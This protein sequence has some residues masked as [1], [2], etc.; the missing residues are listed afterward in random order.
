MVFVQ[1]KI[2]IAAEDEP[3]AE[4]FLDGAG[5]DEVSIPGVGGVKLLPAKAE[6]VRVKLFQQFGLVGAVFGQFGD[7]FHPEAEVLVAEAEA[8]GILEIYVQRIRHTA[9]DEAGLV[10]PV[11]QGRALGRQAANQQQQ[12]CQD[13]WQFSHG[14]LGV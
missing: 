6:A 12:R 13:Q 8:E 14:D 7:E 11:E 3:G 10:E 1:L 2:L 9:V 4:A 5:V